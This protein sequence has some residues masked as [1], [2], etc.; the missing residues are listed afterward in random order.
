MEG[1]AAARYSHLV[2]LV[3]FHWET[4]R[5][6]RDSCLDN[7]SNKFSLAFHLLL[8]D[9]AETKVLSSSRND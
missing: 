1:V 5:E 6:T 9:I 3:A 7:P 2:F 8:R 4:R